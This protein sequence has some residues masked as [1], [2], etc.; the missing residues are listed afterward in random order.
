MC[1]L[2]HTLKTLCNGDKMYI[3][4]VIRIG[5][6]EY[7]IKQNKCKEKQDRFKKIFNEITF[8]CYICYFLI[9]IDKRCNRIQNKRPL[10]GPG[11]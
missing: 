4:L 7:L 1:F 9:I 8:L 10:K 11:I 2:F 5:R 3:Y 6:N